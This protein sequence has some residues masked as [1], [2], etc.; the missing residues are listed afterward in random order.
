MPEG[1]LLVRQLRL[2]LLLVPLLV[3]LDTDLPA[4]A[5]MRMQLNLGLVSLADQ[6][7]ALTHMSQETVGAEMLQ[8]PWQAVPGRQEEPDRSVATRS[9]QVS[10]LLDRAARWLMALLYLP[11][12]LVPQ[13]ALQD[14]AHSYRV[15]PTRYPLM[16]H[17]YNHCR[18]Q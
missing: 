4:V 1:H 6:P 14:Q 7:E 9:Y 5:V 2:V 18:R 17:S 12:T 8:Q 11:Q 15:I 13:Q 16:P 10:M 3:P